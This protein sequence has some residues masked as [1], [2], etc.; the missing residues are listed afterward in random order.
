MIYLASPF[1]ASSREVMDSRYLAACKAA[2]RLIQAGN[3]VFSPIAH[4]YGIH[5]HGGTPCDFQFWRGSNIAWL[6]KC[7][8]MAILTLEGWKT[9]AGVQA[10]IAYCEENEKPIIYLP[11]EWAD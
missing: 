8:S 2:A 9:S 3:F 4:S 1:T 5:Y 11:S 7:D 6:D 10:E